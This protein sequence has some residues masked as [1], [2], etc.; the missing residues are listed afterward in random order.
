MNYESYNEG[1]MV[2]IEERDAW[3]TLCRIVFFLFIIYTQYLQF[4][5]AEISGM[6][7]MLG[8]AT[9]GLCFMGILA[10]Y[11]VVEFVRL[12]E[13]R[14]YCLFFIVSFALGAIGCQLL[15]A[16]L[17][18]WMRSFLYFLLIPCIFFMFENIAEYKKLL[19]FYVW[20]SVLCAITLIVNPIIYKNASVASL[21]NIRYSLSADL[22]VNTLGMYFVLGAWCLLLLMTFVESK[23]LVISPIIL[24]LFLYAIFLTS[25][26]KN[27]IAFIILVAMWA[28]VIWIPQNR[29]KPIKILCA[30]VILTI[31]VIYAYNIFFVGSSLEYRMNNLFLGADAGNDIRENM[32]ENAFELLKKKFITGFGFGG[33]AAYYSG[34]YSHATYA[35]LPACT[36]IV[37]SIIYFRMYFCS[38]RKLI[39]NIMYVKNRSNFCEIKK[40]LYMALIM[41]ILILFYSSCVI[42]FYEL[43]CFLIF[44]FLFVIIRFCEDE[45]ALE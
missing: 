21:N 16:H 1:K 10:K 31:A 38:I 12:K 39:I 3:K 22:N 5:I 42:M 28:V 34:V 44:G 18:S 32:Y 19:L 14:I 41:W 30:V 45:I 26:R 29:N 23:L 37:G 25:S 6:V 40:L 17:E 43:I 27:L 4:V 2:K 11:G 24:V 35:E 36:G 13:Y 15:S 20:F 7:T 8:G 9:I 33:Y